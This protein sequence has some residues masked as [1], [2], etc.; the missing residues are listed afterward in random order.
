MKQQHKF[1]ERFLD[2]DLEKLS[3]ELIERYLRIESQQYSW[4]SKATENDAWFDSQSVS[5]MK[6][7]EYNVFQFHIEGIYNMY[8]A[9]SDML[10]EACDYYELDF[11]EQQFMIQGWFNINYSQTGKLNWHDHG[12]PHPP[13]F[14]GYYCVNAEPSVTHYRVNG[15]EIDNININNRVILSEMGHEHAQGDW[16]W[17]GPRITVAYDIIPLRELV[18]LEPKWEQHWIPIL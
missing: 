13:H 2:N 3:T 10:H 11:E 7:R 12:L 17:N 8:K 5:T 18:G 4:A 1:F 9:V 14:H 16:T 15:K 6:W